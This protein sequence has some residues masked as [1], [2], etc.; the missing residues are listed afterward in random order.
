M[1]TD[2]RL[3]FSTSKD[4]APLVAHNVWTQ[5]VSFNAYRGLLEFYS[6]HFRMD[7]LD[8]DRFF[9][10]AD[11]LVSLLRFLRTTFDVNM[12]IFFWFEDDDL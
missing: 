6:D 12:E 9:A 7:D 3:R 10:M 5:D 8:L 1:G 11:K 2:Y 4:S